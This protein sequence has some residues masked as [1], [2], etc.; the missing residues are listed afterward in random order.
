M[1]GEASCEDGEIAPFD[2]AWV[3][4]D[5]AKVLEKKWRRRWTARKYIAWV[6]TQ[7]FE[8]M[9]PIVTYKD[10]RFGSSRPLKMRENGIK[11]V[12]RSSVDEVLGIVREQVVDWCQ[13]QGRPPFAIVEIRPTR[14]EASPNLAPAA[15]PEPAECYDPAAEFRGPFVMSPESVNR[16]PNRTL[17]AQAKAVFGQLRSWAI[18]AQKA[19]DGV[20]IWAEPGSGRWVRIGRVEI[21]GR[22]FLEFPMQGAHGC[23][24]RGPGYF[25]GCVESF[26]ACGFDLVCGHRGASI[27]ERCISAK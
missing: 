19:K 10:G 22:L 20:L 14:R 2:L 23:A 9:V 21:E 12:L 13:Q 1:S 24:G 15:M 16:V 17:G 8:C 5:R 26:A 3:S 7:D 11:A 18:R 4:V 6:R 27:L 25:A